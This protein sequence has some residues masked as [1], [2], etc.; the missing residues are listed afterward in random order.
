[1]NEESPS[2]REG[3]KSK[4]FPVVMRTAILGVR[5]VILTD[6]NSVGYCCHENNQRL[7][8]AGHAFF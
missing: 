3:R 6:I 8:T 1:M 2:F 5:S 7:G 4:L